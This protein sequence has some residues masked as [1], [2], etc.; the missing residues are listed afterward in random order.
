MNMLA[1]PI[2]ML[3]LA[4]AALALAGPAAAQGKLVVYT[5]NDSDRTRCVCDALRRESKIEVEPVE[6]GAGVLF[7]R[8]AS[9]KERPLGD[10][11][12]G[13][14]R[15]LLRA[16]AALLAPYASKNKDAVPA[17]FRD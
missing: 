17:H 13:V 9:A 8:M 12:W 5:E 16:N 10:I 1:R 14:R 3:F 15:T 4:C 11:V 7:R 6:A 2:T